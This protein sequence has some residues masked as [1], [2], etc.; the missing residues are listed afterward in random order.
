MKTRTQQGRTRFLCHLPSHAAKLYTLYSFLNQYHTFECSG[1]GKTTVAALMSRFYAP[2]KGDLLL[3]GQAAASFT[4]GEWARAVS[5]V[6]QEPVLFGGKHHD[7]FLILHTQGH[8]MFCVCAEPCVMTKVS[9]KVC[10]KSGFRAQGLLANRLP[11]S[12]CQ[13]GLVR[14]WETTQGLPSVRFC[15]GQE[16]RN[17]LQVPLGTISRMGDMGAVHN[18]K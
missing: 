7:A 14:G 4:R 3:D 17:G 18:K 2:D 1:A 8:S 15:G 12:S 6:Q 13:T 9:L 16:C 11:G 5:V 10:R